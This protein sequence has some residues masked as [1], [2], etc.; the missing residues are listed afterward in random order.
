MDHTQT[1][2][3][4]QVIYLIIEYPRK[5]WG[6]CFNDES[7]IFFYM[8]SL[9]QKP[10]YITDH[11]YMHKHSLCASTI[12]TTLDRELDGWSCLSLKWWEKRGSHANKDK[13]YGLKVNAPW[14]VFPL[15][16]ANRNILINVKACPSLSGDTK[17][18]SYPGY[19]LSPWKSWMWYSLS[20]CSTHPWD[21]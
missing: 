18:M 12:K 5:K 7:W 17:I 3:V 6:G 2:Q 1:K 20:S 9:T 11:Y 21:P 13:G 14:G 19:K 4:L 15:L 16:M 10:L 8:K